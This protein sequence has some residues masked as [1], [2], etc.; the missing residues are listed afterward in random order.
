M[1][2]IHHDVARTDHC[3][4]LAHVEG[5]IAESRQAIE[6][7][8][9]IFGM[10]HTVGTIPF[11]ANRLCTLCPNGKHD[12]TGASRADVF[13]GQIFALADR[14]VPQVMDVRLCQEFPVLLFQPASE[15]EF[16]GKYAILSQSAELN[17]AIENNDFMARFGER[18]CDRQSS[19]TGT[20]HDNHVLLLCAHARDL[21]KMN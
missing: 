10:E 13:H 4:M 11:H 14:D 17:I 3:H 7:I 18:C 2:D 1:G 19:W 21:E 6:V 20:G 12:R 8:D 5:A 16:T 9:H 15:F